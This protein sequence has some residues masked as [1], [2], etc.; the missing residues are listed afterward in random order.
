MTLTDI[1]TNAAQAALTEQ[2]V[3]YCVQCGS[4]R[5]TDMTTSDCVPCYNTG[6]HCRLV[7]GQKDRLDRIARWYD[8]FKEHGYSAK[9]LRRVPMWMNLIYP[10]VCLDLKSTVKGGDK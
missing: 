4:V 10:P 9:D 7:A 3:A 8:F 2:H 5:P 6:H 1:N